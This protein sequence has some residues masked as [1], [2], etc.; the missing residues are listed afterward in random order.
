[1]YQEAVNACQRQDASS[2]TV[3]SGSDDRLRV[4]M[5]VNDGMMC[6][7][8]ANVVRCDEVPATGST[9]ECRMDRVAMGD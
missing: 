6:R 1:M 5:G 4:V 7:L 2:V 8:A 9:A 3:A